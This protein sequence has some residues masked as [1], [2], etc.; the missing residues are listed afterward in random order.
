MRTPEEGM[1]LRVFIG[2]T[3]SYKSK[4][5][6]DQ[7]VLKA[8]ELHL[9][10]VT[11]TRGIMGYGADNKIHTSKILRLS[12][13][14]PIIIE[15]IDSEDNLKTILPFLDETIGDGF[16]T[17]EKVSILCIPANQDAIPQSWSRGRPRCLKPLS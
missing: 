2:E 17:M 15:I 5:L 11:V 3:D 9:A 7:I 10:S 13:D 16:V 6:Y 14:L 4:A 1:L 8:K 12:D